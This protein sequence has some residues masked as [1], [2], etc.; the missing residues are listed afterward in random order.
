MFP[1]EIVEKLITLASMILRFQDS[2]ATPRKTLSRLGHK[3]IGVKK[4]LN[5]RSAQPFLAKKKRLKCG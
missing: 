3:I 2:P 4:Q 1:A 5:K